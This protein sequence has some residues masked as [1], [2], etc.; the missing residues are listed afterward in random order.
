MSEIRKL[1]QG[2]SSVPGKIYG[3]IQAVPQSMF[4]G[5]PVLDD[6]GIENE[7]IE[8]TLT[9]NSV[10]EGQW[11]DITV[12]SGLIILYPVSANS[13]GCKDG[14][15]GIDGLSAYEIWLAEGNVGTQQNFLESL[16]GA[17]GARGERG[18]EGA[19]GERGDTGFDGPQGEQGEP[20]E[21][22]EQ[23]EQG[24]PGKDGRDGWDGRDGDPGPRGE[25]GLQGIQGER[26]YEGPP[27]MDGR[28]A[29]QLWILKG[30]TGTQQ[31]FLDSLKGAD[32]ID[33][34]SAYEIWLSEGNSGTPQDYLNAIKGEPGTSGKSGS[35]GIQGIQGPQGEKGDQGEPGVSALSNFIGYKINGITGVVDVISTIIKDSGGNDF[36]PTRT[37][38]GSKIVL[39]FTGGFIDGLQVD[40]NSIYPMFQG[41]NQE[42]FEQLMG[43]A[44]NNEAN[45]I[46]IDSLSNSTGFDFTM[47][48]FSALTTKAPPANFDITGDWN[49]ARDSKGNSTP[50]TDEQSF[51]D[52]LNRTGFSNISIAGFELSNGR[53]K[54]NMVATASTLNLSAMN[55][56]EVNMVPP[57]VGLNTLGL[58]DNQIVN[59][60]P[61]LPLPDS[62]TNLGLGKNLLTSFDPIQLLPLNLSFLELDQ[63]SLTEFKPTNL[64]PSTISNIRLDFN[65]ID[66][67][68]Y[69]A[70]E[71]WA[72]NQSFS[73][74]SQINFRYNSSS[75]SG[76]NLEA[77]LLS[78]NVT[79][80]A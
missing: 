43:Y 28:T 13:G 61:I 78:K 77:I 73:A 35:Q 49:L 8:M 21:P 72:S 74:N 80:V 62:I 40:V 7:P 26:G 16:K 60:D 3:K 68:G 79:V 46:R 34:L 70:M 27:G 76:T 1:A 2:E 29:Y 67:V 69:Q 57:L 63:N 65:S 11:K 48:S 41:L 55:I 15:D 17:D 32:G 44:I 39:D 10:S 45:Q 25:R 18:Y 6:D 59:F 30:N 31:D 75:V 37:V 56:T 9:V 52:Y 14:I 5:T 58:F 4:R 38:E 20:G 22:G 42:M 47:Q 33:G 54:C 19:K 53:L 23:G 66:A 12:I 51:I 24:E 50:V 64:L 36:A 71:Q